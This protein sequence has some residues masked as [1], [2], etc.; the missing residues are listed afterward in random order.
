MIIREVPADQKI[1]AE[2]LAALL[3][4]IPVLDGDRYLLMG[5]GA[6]INRVEEARHFRDR[7]RGIEL[8]KAM[9]FNAETVFRERYTQVAS[10]TLDIN[11]ST[12]F[13]VL[14]EASSTGESRD[15][16][17]RRLLRPSVDQAIN[18]LSNRLSEENEDL[19]R[20]SL[21]KWCASKQ[22]M[23]EFDSRDLQEGD[24]AIPVLNHRISHD[25]MPDDL[26]KYSRYFLKNLFRLN[27]IYRNYEFFYPPE[28]IE[29]YWE[30][31]SPDQG[32]FDMKII[33]DHGVMEL[34]LYNVSRR[35]GLERTRNPDY[36][37]I[38]EF[39]AKDARK[40][41]IKGCRISV[42]GQTSEDDE[43]L[44]QMM[45]IETDGSDSPIPGAA[46]CIAYN[47]SEEGLEKFRKL[48]S[49]LSG[50]RAEVLFPVSEQTV[51]RNDLT[52]LDFNIDINEKTGR[53][54]LDG[55]EAS[56][57][58]MHEIVVLIGKKLLDL[59]KQAYRD[60][61]NFP[62]PNVEELDAEVH[63]LIAEAEEEGLTEE[64]A[65]EIVAK[66]TILDYY[67]ALARYSF[68]LSD[69]IIKYLESK[70]TITFTMPRMLIAL[71]NRIL[72]EQSADDI[73]LENLGA[74]Q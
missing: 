37:G 1:D 44:K 52:F 47:L 33:P 16:L 10:R 63:R 30:F 45:L 57:R 40:R 72:V 71:L 66:I 32:T 53:F 46:G 8:A 23:K 38:A 14:E 39:L 6:V 21:E 19:L 65:R 50:I 70:Q 20:F 51:G 49:E 12:L 74:S 15:E 48:L 54:Q 34:R 22:Q 24:V 28:I 69:Q 26:H 58:S 42:H 36:Y 11:T 3:D 64:M 68:V 5:R 59:S 73:I 56:E 2:I 18:D 27:N 43:K 13:R 31:I 67:E 62:Q 29:R 4:L 17:M 25:E 7:D 41:C 9:E 55:A 61:E 35:F 60:P